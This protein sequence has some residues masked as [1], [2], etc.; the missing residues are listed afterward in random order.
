MKTLHD[1]EISEGFPWHIHPHY[2]DMH[3]T[4]LL[5]W[6][7]SSEGVPMWA[8]YGCVD[9]DSPFYG[10]VQSR[11]VEEGRRSTSFGDRNYFSATYHKWLKNPTPHWYFTQ[12]TRIFCLP[13]KWQL[14][15]KPAA[16]VGDV[17]TILT[18]LPD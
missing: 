18:R 1:P 12:A 17:D 2:L 13:P 3:C 6:V 15:A 16:K 8:Y 4:V 14:T 9:S 11:A 5:G 7:E 10:E